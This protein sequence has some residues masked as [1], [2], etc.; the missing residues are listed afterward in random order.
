MR[1]PWLIICKLLAPHA[2]ARVLRVGAEN[3]RDDPVKDDE[4]ESAEAVARD[5]MRQR[6]RIAMVSLDSRAPENSVK[7]RLREV[8][9]PFFNLRLWVHVPHP[10]F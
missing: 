10:I 6:N 4:S 8:K 7:V 9:V 3:A 1:L 5:A 2:G